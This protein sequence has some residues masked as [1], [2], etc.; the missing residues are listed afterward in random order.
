MNKVCQNFIGGDLV[1]A[2]ASHHT[3]VY[4]PSR[5]KVIAQAPGS[6][7]LSVERAV[8]AAK[9]AFR[10]RADT[11]VVERARDVAVHASA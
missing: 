9:N 1:P 7:A 8:Q 4:N 3:S 2:T 5:S 6:D 10:S 11:P